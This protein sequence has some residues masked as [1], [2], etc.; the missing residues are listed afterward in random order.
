MA[1]FKSR[2]EAIKGAIRKLRK[3]DQTPIEIPASRKTIPDT[4]AMVRQYVQEALVSAGGSV[5]AYDTVEDMLKEELDLE[6][7]DPDPPWTSQYEVSEMDDV[8][9]EPP[10]EETLP[11]LQK[12]GEA[13]E[14]ES[15]SDK[16]E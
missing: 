2:R 10:R 7:E 3:L 16:N 9:P 14:T 4:K 13:T 15:S 11:A 1:T 5:E 6:P 12:E 8:E